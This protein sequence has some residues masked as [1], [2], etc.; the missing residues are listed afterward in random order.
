MLQRFTLFIVCVK[1]FKISIL[2]FSFYLKILNK[3]T[4]C[5]GPW[6]FGTVSFCAVHFPL[7]KSEIISAAECALKILTIPYVKAS[8]ISNS[9]LPEPLKRNRQMS[10][11]HLPTQ[12]ITF[13]LSPNN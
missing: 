5:S 1:L 9:T 12:N 2:L 6:H 10:P 3:G 8:L 7:G 11:Q 4:L 13:N